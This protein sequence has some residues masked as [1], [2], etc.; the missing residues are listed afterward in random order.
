MVD[1]EHE[2]EAADHE[3]E[4]TNLSVEDAMSDAAGDMAKT[5]SEED[6]TSNAA[7]T[8]N[9]PTATAEDEPPA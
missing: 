2:S 8:T 5:P 3:A 6:P 7:E 9:G 1:H 4:E